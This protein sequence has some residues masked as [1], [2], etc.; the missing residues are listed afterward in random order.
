ME[1]SMTLSKSERSKK[2]KNAS[3][4]GSNFQRK[5]AKILTLGA[6]EDGIATDFH[7]TPRSGGLRWQK[8]T[9]VIGDVTCTRDDFLFTVECKKHEELDYQKL[10]LIRTANSV[11]DFISFW[12][13][14]CD[15]AIRAK[16][17]P[18]LVVEK[19]RG[20]PVVV[21]PSLLYWNLICNDH[22]HGSIL[23]NIHLS[24]EVL[25]KSFDLQQNFLSYYG[26]T[27]PLDW[28]AVALLQLCDFV[29]LVNF[30]YL[31]TQNCATKK[32]TS[33]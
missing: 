27:I 7:S 21:L 1:D 9:D 17:Q 19:K 32:R 2:A 8:R 4:R 24:E 10:F 3:Q 23:A 14:A 18:M 25:E 5:V 30:K 26:E 29:E 33:I 20:K 15:E 28:E 31:F 11:D 13:Q 6:K 16:K 12:E 22:E